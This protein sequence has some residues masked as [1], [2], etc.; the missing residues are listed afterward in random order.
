MYSHTGIS[1]DNFL[2][3]MLELEK[4]E[5]VNRKGQYKD[6]GNIGHRTTT[7]KAKQQHRKLIRR[8]TRTPP[9]SRDEART[10]KTSNTDPIKRTRDEAR[11]K[12]TSNTDPIKIKG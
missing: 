12:K 1:L 8:V 11:T 9:K 5:E 10:K 6:T 3:E 2:V 7:N 4:G